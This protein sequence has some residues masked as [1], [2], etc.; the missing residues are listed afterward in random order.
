[1]ENNKFFICKHCKNLSGIIFNSGVPMVCCGENMTLL[2]ANTV[3]ASHEKHMPKV[4][5]NGNTIKATVGEVIHPMIV[6]HHI[7]WIYLE[8]VKGGQRKKCSDTPE[9]TFILADDD[10]PISVFAYCNLHGL[11][12]KDI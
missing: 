7:E 11:W 12:R 10:K 2:E 6:E 9:A 3:D 5:I 1:M 8:T 4:E